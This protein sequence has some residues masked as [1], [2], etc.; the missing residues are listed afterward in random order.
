MKSSQSTIIGSLIVI[1]ITVILGIAMLSW[2][3]SAL[4][5]QQSGFASIYNTR[6]QE[7]LDNYNIEYVYENSS[8]T[9][10]VWV[11]NY[12]P[13]VVKIVEIVVYNT[14]Y[15]YSKSLSLAVPPSSLVKITLS[16]LSLSKNSVYYIKLIAEDGSWEVSSF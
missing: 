11:G 10:T 12:G 3:M 8:S 9:L 6:L 7:L 4:S 16:G 5:V 13:T 1:V 14:T 15:T 2:G